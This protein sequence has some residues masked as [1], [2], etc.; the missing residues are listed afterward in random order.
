MHR[1]L[2]LILIAA[3][4]GDDGPPA[5]EPLTPDPDVETGCTSRPG[6][7]QTRAKVVA[8]DDELIGGRLAGGRIGD[9]LLENE[10]VRVIVRGGDTGYYLLGAGPGGIIDAA[11]ADGEDLVKEILPAID[12]AVGALDELVIVEAGDDGPAELV[13][14]GPATGLEIVSA[15]LA[16]P[17]PPVIIEHR[18][19]LAADA[20]AVELET[21]AFAAEGGVAA[22]HDVYE[23][24]FFGGRARAFVPGRGFEPGSVGAEILATGGTT[25]SYGLVYPPDAANPQLID[26]A[27]IRLARGPNVVEG[28]A[29][30]RWFVIGDGSVSSVTGA[31]WA[32]RGDALGT[33][34]G[35]TAPGADVI[36]TSG[37][38]P[39]TIA[40]ADADGEFALDVPPGGYVVHAEALGREPGGVA[41]VTVAAGSTDTLDL[42]VG[43]GGTIALTVRDD[44]GAPIPARIVLSRAG[45]DDRITFVGASGDATLPVAPG[46]WR[47]TVSRGVEYD[48]VVADPL[49][50]ADDEVTTLDAVLEHVVDTAGWISVDTHLHSELSTDSTFPV[51]DRLRAV[52]A[53]GVEVAVSTDHDFITDYGPIIDELG[54]GAWLGNLIGEEAS[55]LVWGHINAFPLT[56][57]LDL[58]ARGAVSWIGRTPGEVFEGL[59]DRGAGVVQV[60][61]PRRGSS[62]LFDAIDLDPV[63]LTAGTDPRDLGLPA[64]ADLSDLSFDAFELANASSD[65]AFEQV[66]VDFLA[67]T[68]AG[69]PAAAMGSSDSHGISAFAGE[70]RSYVWVGDGA[71]DPATVDADAIVEGIRARHVVIA[72]GS[73]VTAGVVTS[74]G[75]SLPGDTVDVTGQPD[76]QLHIT[77]QAAPWQ[78]LASIRIYQGTQLLQMITLDPDDTAPVRY[79]ADVTIATPAADTF[80]VVR[81]DPAGAGDP[82]LGDSMP[83]IT[84]PVFVQVD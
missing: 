18:Y 28:V 70:A 52:A 82:V 80:W 29:A 1:G 22:S 9:F 2:L 38:A 57:E 27:G 4:C 25:S 73:F 66:L 34:R 43:S 83:S 21:R 26:L 15:A 48:A 19:R 78:A 54:L 24:M 69:H 35:T 44:A 61:H 3:G 23:A 64:D 60:N 31:A 77:V 16:T 65:D 14:R 46:T 79:D 50:V 37:D 58:P 49:T 84:N 75:V 11:S 41:T 5:P 71:D 45:V 6:P 36:V 20:T 8:C 72:T 56:P 62:S 67:M 7:G 53:E 40:R 30:R 17:P 76:V 12:L 10:H 55:S 33:I 13:V 63:T 42:P 47:V 74:G 81:V 59:R 68:E 51:D 32:L 39:L